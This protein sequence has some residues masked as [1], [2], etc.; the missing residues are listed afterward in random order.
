MADR[1]RGTTDYEQAIQAVLLAG[2]QLVA[3]YSTTHG[4]DRG[5]D[6]YESRPDAIAITSH[7]LIIYE[8][9]L[10][11]GD[12]EDWSLESV[13]YSRIER[14]KVSASLDLNRRRPSGY[15]EIVLRSTYGSHSLRVST[16]MSD[17]DTARLAHAQILAK[18]LATGS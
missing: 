2:E 1:R 17:P 18:L 13:P 14:L 10:W 4:D 15:I 6:S 8:H 7:R 11:R 12:R 3:V 16:P 5:S 9:Y